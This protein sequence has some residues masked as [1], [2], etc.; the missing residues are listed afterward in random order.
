MHTA[1]FAALTSAA[2]LRRVVLRQAGVCATTQRRRIASSAVEGIVGDGG[3]ARKAV[4][5]CASNRIDRTDTSV[6]GA[7]GALM[8]AQ[9]NP[10]LSLAQGIV[11]WPPPEAAVAAATDALRAGDRSVHAYGSTHGDPELQRELLSKLEHENGIVQSKVMVTMGANQ[12][13][14]NIVVSLVDAG[15][16]VVL[17]RPYV[18]SLASCDADVRVVHLR[19]PSFNSARTR[20]THPST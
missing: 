11:H 13:F 19:R 14:T 20:Y 10:V 1:L 6:I 2:V 15:D 7:I 12:A 9:N 17:F 8:R 5:P 18:Y 4:Q 3:R 16:R